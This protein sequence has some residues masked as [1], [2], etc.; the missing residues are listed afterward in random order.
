M[1]HVTDVLLGLADVHVEQFG[2]LHAQEVEG[3]FCGHGL[4][5]EGLAYAGRAVPEGRY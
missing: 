3:T 1:K 2:S 4:G 5:Q